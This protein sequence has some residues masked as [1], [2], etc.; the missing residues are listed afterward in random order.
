MVK[1]GGGGV[2]FCRGWLLATSPTGAPCHAR[3]FVKREG[4]GVAFVSVRMECLSRCWT[5]GITAPVASAS[6]GRLHS[7]GKQMQGE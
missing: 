3:C 7:K 6:A 2:S 5:Y 4:G 1:E